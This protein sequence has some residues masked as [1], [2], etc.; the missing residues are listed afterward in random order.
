MPKSSVIFDFDGVLADSF[1]VL[2][3]LNSDAMHHIGR[4]L[5]KKDYRG[6]FLDNIHSGL[7]RLIDNDEKLESLRH[8]K[9]NNF[10]R[11]YSKAR[12]FRFTK[13]L[14][15][16]LSQICNLGIVSSTQEGFIKELLEK[17]GVGD[18]FQII[19]GSEAHSKEK[20]LTRAAAWMNSP[21]D[22][23]FFITDTVGDINVGK[24]LGFNTLAV[25]WG[26]HGKGLLRAACPENIFSDD[27]ALFR[28]LSD[29]A[30]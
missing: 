29:R 1:D 30:Q 3:T 20:E 2:F 12:L 4:S 23:T 14:T 6:L 10:S 18:F 8:F 9:K 27:R 13:D 19:S 24:K 11:Y 26:F 16:S 7:R 28:H 17:N 21:P 22:Q 5:T 25:T 15:A